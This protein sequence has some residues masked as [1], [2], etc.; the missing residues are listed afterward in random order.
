MKV[1][2]A[3]NAEC[4]EAGV[5]ARDINSGA[6]APPAQLLPLYERLADIIRSV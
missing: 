6:V 2:S 4:Y 3:A 5:S 1:D